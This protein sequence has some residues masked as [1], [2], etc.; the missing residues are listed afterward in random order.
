MILNQLSVKEDF[1]I[2][3]RDQVPM[4]IIGQ[5]FCS[6]DCYHIL[7]RSLFLKI[8]LQ[9]F[10]HQG[11]PSKGGFT[12]NITKSSRTISIKPRAIA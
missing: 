2:T 1:Q 7:R 12:C 6:Y 8:N 10:V 4:F 11:S 3:W 9:V 5:R